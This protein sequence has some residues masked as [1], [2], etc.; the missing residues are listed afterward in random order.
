MLV[1]QRVVSKTLGILTIH[2]LANASSAPDRQ[3]NPW[4]DAV[5][6]LGQGSQNGAFSGPLPN[7]V[8]T[9]VLGTTWYNLSTLIHKSFMIHHTYCNISNLSIH[10]GFFLNISWTIHGISIG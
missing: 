5:I 1:Y 7:W 6:G 3:T 10:N 9:G 2:E 8:I 4:H